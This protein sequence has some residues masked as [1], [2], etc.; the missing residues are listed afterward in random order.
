M[1]ADT[2]MTDVRAGTSR[3]DNNT[4]FVLVWARKPVPGFNHETGEYDEDPP[5]TIMIASRHSER[6]S[7]HHER[8]QRTAEGLV[9][10]QFQ[11]DGE[12]LTVPDLTERAQMV[13]SALEQQIPDGYPWLVTDE[14][15]AC[16]RRGL[17]ER[18]I[19]SIASMKFINALTDPS[20]D[21]EMEDT[22]MVGPVVDDVSQKLI[23]RMSGIGLG[24]L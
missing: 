15:T 19:R 22:E 5:P 1:D 8:S 9:E 2:S 4:P 6:T 21:S 3:V 13:I 17:P 10:L 12:A 18:R 16:L 24:V 20:V 14:A 7:R 23:Q 11:S